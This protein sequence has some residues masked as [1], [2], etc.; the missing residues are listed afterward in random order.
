MNEASI[1]VIVFRVAYMPAAPLPPAP[2]HPIRSHDSG[3]S[4]RRKP[5]SALG[6]VSDDRS[7]WGSLTYTGVGFPN[8]LRR[9]PLT[10]F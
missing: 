3:E 1:Q 2:R 9:S 5:R 7:F 6:Y 4:E 8:V 10:A